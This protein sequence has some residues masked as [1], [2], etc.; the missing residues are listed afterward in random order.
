MNRVW[1]RLFALAL[2]LLPLTGCATH[3]IPNTDVEDND[4]NRE[5]IEF[6]EKYRHAVEYRNVPLLLQMAHDN[7]YEDG[8]TVDTSDDIDKAGLAEY[9]QGRFKDTTG[10]RYEIRYRAV[11][12]GR[13]QTFFVDF[14]YSASYKIPTSEGEAWRRRVADDRLEL[15]RDGESFKILS[16]M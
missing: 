10:I 8:G 12:P 15:V 3:Y 16:G 6:C 13:K 11:S 9:L 2:G 7:Y 1:Y 5:L 14:T 4:F